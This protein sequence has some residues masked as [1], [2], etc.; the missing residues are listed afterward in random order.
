MK[1]ARDAGLLFAAPA[2]LRHAVTGAAPGYFVVIELHGFYVN[3][4]HR[5]ACKARADAGVAAGLLRCVIGASALVNTHPLSGWMKVIGGWTFVHG[6][7]PL[8]VLISPRTGLHSGVAAAHAC[9]A[10]M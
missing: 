1:K 5:F 7:A 8:L 9:C 4:S 2:R 3:L 10:I 6:A